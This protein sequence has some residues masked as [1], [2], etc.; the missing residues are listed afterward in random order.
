MRYFKLPGSFIPSFLSCKFIPLSRTPSIYYRPK[1]DLSST[2]PNS[3]A[4]P[5]SSAAMLSDQK[6]ANGHQAEYNW[7]DGAESL[8]KY[9]PGGYHPITIGDILNQRYR[10]VDKLGFGV[11]STV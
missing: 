1:L 10:I 2:Q 6:D 4:P 7:V 5:F 9:R 11:Y 3:T 8:E